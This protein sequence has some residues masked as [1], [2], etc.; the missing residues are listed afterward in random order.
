MNKHRTFQFLFAFLLASFV[1][2]LMIPSPRV[3][4]QQAA[5]Y[6]IRNARIVTV[7]GQTIERGTVVIRD[8]KIAEV[9]ASVSV[10][11]NAKVIEGRGL[12]VYPGLI[13]SGTT[14]GLTEVGS[15][16]ETRDTTEL[17]DFNPHMRA[18]VAVNPHSELIPVARANG[19]TTALTSPTGRLMSGQASLINLDGWTWKEMALKPSVALAMEWPAAAAGRFAAFLPPEATQNLAQQRERQLTALRQKLDDAKAYAQAKEAREKDKSLPARPTDF[20]LEALIPVVKG[21]MPVIITASSER[22]I[23]GAIELADKYKLKLILRDADDAWK[24]ASTLKEKNI[25]VIIGPVTE[26]PRREDDDYDLQYSHAAKLY[27]AGVRFAFQTSDAAYVRNLPFQAGTAAAFGLPKDEALKAVTIYPAQIFGVDKLVGSIEPGKIA[28]L[29]VTDGD[30][31]EF[32]T[33]VKHMFINGHPVDLSSRH[34][35]L[36]DKFASRP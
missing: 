17:G 27:K 6:A 20:V 5:V 35:K 9:G 24:V 14:L 3:T 7:T 32:K 19:V 2:V 36:Y 28:N 22:D 21:E 23:K 11:G 26:V 29:I 18:L 30:P 34:T 15:V 16:Q 1:A 13:D 10:P 8:G 4:A 33:N 31:L 25:P 12:S